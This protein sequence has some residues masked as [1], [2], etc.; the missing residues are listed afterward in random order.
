MGAGHS[1]IHEIGHLVHEDSNW[2]A[3]KNIDMCGQGDI[4]I[5]RDWR[6]HH[7]IEELKR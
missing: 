7:S 5:I 3:Y 4:E 6:R 2:W 1:E